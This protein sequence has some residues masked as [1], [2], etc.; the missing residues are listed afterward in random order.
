MDSIQNSIAELSEHFNARMAEFQRNLQ[1]SIPATSPTSNITAQ[2][3][4][5]RSFVLTA[6]DGLQQL[7]DILTR[8]YEE[9]EMRSRR[10]ILLLHGIPE[11]K[12]EKVCSVAIKTLNDHLKLS[13][14]SVDTVKRCHR[15]GQFNADKP[16]AILIKFTDLAL[17]NKI[18]FAKTALKNS[19]VTMSEFLT[20]E[21]HN[22]FL[23]ARQRFGVTKCWTKDG[24]IVVLGSDGSHHRIFKM[25]D[26]NAVSSSSGVAA[27]STSG[28]SFPSTSQSQ[29]DGKVINQTRSKRVIKK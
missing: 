1:N 19:G 26:L 22:I 16:R 7:V 9:M 17:R 2:F 18:W 10:K 24:Q 25:A 11:T 20:K 23:A 5:F 12:N 14:I 28:A 21:R 3:N 15:L 29:K 27:A 6:L 8:K 13:N 4:S